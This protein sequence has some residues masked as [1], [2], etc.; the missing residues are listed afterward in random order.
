MFTEVK[1]KQEK[2]INYTLGLGR[3]EDNLVWGSEAGGRT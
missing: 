3:K 1:L 2:K